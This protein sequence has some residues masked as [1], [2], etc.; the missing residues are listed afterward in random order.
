MSLE[1]EVETGMATAPTAEVNVAVNPI[2]TFRSAGLILSVGLPIIC[3]S[4]I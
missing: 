3:N 4:F 2:L 1:W